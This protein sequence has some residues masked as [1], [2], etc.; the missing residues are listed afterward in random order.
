MNPVDWKKGCVG[1][2]FFYSLV[3]FITFVVVVDGCGWLWMVVVVFVLLV[4]V[5]VLIFVP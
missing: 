5:L 1:I 4:L 2:M 3:V